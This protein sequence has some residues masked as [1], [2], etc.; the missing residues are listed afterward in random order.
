MKRIRTKIMISMIICSMLATLLLGWVSI[1]VGG[2]AIK[3]EAKEKFSAVTEE[4][5]EDFNG[6]FENTELAIEFLSNTILSEFDLSKAKDNTAYF[7]QYQQR[8]EPVVEKFAKTTKGAMGVYVSLNPDLT[9][10]QYGVWY[11]ATG[12]DS[13]F[14]KQTITKIKDYSSDDSEHVG[15]YYAPIK[16]GKGVWLEPYLNKN[17]NKKMISYVKPLYV[18]KNLIGVVGI[19]IDFDTIVDST[20]EVKIYETGYAFLMNSK[21]S[22]LVHPTFNEKDN[23]A[24]IDNGNLK[25]VSEDIQKNKIGVLE[26]KIN[27]QSKILSYMHLN[28]SFILAVTAPEDEV[29]KSTNRLKFLILLIGGIQ[30][31]V[32]AV[33]SV[34]ISNKI[35]KPIKE[36]TNTLSRISDYD[37][38]S[39]LDKVNDVAKQKDELSIMAKE[40][41]NMQKELGNLI[42]SVK[43]NTD[44]IADNSNNLSDSMNDATSSIEGI[45]KAT[46]EM[47][48]GASN[49]ARNIQDSTEKLELLAQEIDKAEGSSSSIKWYIEDT[50][51]SNSAGIDAA[52]KLDASVKENI[53]VLQKLER[54][55]EILDVKSQSINVITDT[56]KGI[57]SNINLLSLNASIEAARAGA[58]GKGF[59]VVAEEIRKL[60][61][62]TASSTK[63]IENII[64]EIKEEIRKTEEQLANS[65]E[66]ITKMNSTST[67]TAKVFESI[68]RSTKNIIDQVNSL[69]GSIKSIYG[70]K[71]TIIG[72]VEEISAVSEQYAS[73][74]E[75]ISASIQEQYAVIEQISQSSNELKKIA[76]DLENIISKFKI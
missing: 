42:K 53:S 47:A 41:I 62:E 17:I 25:L 22:F 39:D 6:I 15:W 23:M 5:A 67:D 69:T 59:S 31:I 9:S 1:F 38:A 73:T 49:L 76:L 52:K 57:T 30:L 33:I 64:R 10:E 18:E 24:S 65:K 74:T 54:Q 45:A 51:A 43:E 56:I 75:E 27:N 8:I 19:D 71:N 11:A 26:C 28:N 7:S 66:V 48:N 70:S 29:L 4:K 72:S 58:A 20:N 34:F 36:V 2:N 40:L 16:A 68:N 44:M 55:V 60:A 3:K 13:K 21:Q 12:E 35:S 63:K 32:I 14:T 50:I 46:D 37:L 61:Y